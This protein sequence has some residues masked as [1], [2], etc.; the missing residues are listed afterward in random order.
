MVSLSFVRHERVCRLFEFDENMDGTQA[1]RLLLLMCE[2]FE[3]VLV[4]SESSCHSTNPSST[5]SKLSY[6]LGVTT[7]RILVSKQQVLPQRTDRTFEKVHKWFHNRAAGS[8]KRAV[9]CEKLFEDDN[10]GEAIRGPDLPCTSTLVGRCSALKAKCM[11]FSDQCG[12]SF[13]TV[14]SIRPSI[15]YELHAQKYDEAF[16]NSSLDALEFINTELLVNLPRTRLCATRNETRNSKFK[17]L[18]STTTFA[19]LVLKVISVSHFID[20]YSKALNM[21]HEPALA[22]IRAK[23]EAG[24]LGSMILLIRGIVVVPVDTCALQA[25]TLLDLFVWRPGVSPRLDLCR[26]A[27]CRAAQD[28][29]TFIIVKQNACGF[30]SRKLVYRKCAGFIWYVARADVES[31]GLDSSALIVCKDSAGCNL[32]LSSVELDRM[33][34]RFISA[35]EEARRGVEAICESSRSILAGVQSQVEDCLEG[36]QFL[37]CFLE[38]SKACSLDLDLIR[39]SVNSSEILSAVNAAS[40]PLGNKFPAHSFFLLRCLPFILITGP[41][42]SGK[43]T[44]VQNVLKTAETVLSKTFVRA[45]YVNC[46]LFDFVHSHQTLTSGLFTSHFFSDLTKIDAMIA[47]SN[48]NSLVLLDEPFKSTSPLEAGYILWALLEVLYRRSVKVVLVSH[49]RTLTDFGSSYIFPQVLSLATEEKSGEVS[50]DYKLREHNINRSSVHYGVYQA[51][52]S[53]LPID[54]LCR[55]SDFAV[56]KLHGGTLLESSLAVTRY[57]HLIAKIVQR[58]LLSLNPNHESNSDRKSELVTFLSQIAQNKRYDEL[59]SM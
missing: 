4:L 15:R 5:L 21:V 24:K 41:N 11:N 56:S 50:F 6:I 27:L 54:I 57:K 29:F 3:T 7:F 34:A 30:R 52:S 55:A 18:D 14:P 51:R 35:L 49:L 23:M 37:A 39:P 2:G 48:L 16:A 25:R 45:D 13:V 28:I 20:T 33:N 10:I 44:C 58:V 47:S 46:H 19:E 22:E 42:L 59:K 1:L 53:K 32:Q 31:V 36:I 43:S 38:H 26:G 12:I 9:L 8:L 40:V 17:R